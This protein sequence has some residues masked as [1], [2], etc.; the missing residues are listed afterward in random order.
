MQTLPDARTLPRCEAPPAGAARAA[1]HFCREHLPRQSGPQHEDDA[2]E[3]RAIV[4]GRAAAAPTSAPAPF[5]EQWLD[6]GPQRVVDELLRHAGLYQA[7][8]LGTRGLSRVLKRAL[9]N[10]GIAAQGRR[11]SCT[12]LTPWPFQSRS[13]SGASALRW[14]FSRSIGRSSLLTSHDTWPIRCSVQELPLPRIWKKQDLRTRVGI[15]R[16]SRPSRFE[17]PESAAAGCVW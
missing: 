13:R 2:G 12:E 4:D 16:P 5:G 8:R 9:R 17:K 14:T 15:S 10:K 3:R 1:A 11:Q 6:P 7:S